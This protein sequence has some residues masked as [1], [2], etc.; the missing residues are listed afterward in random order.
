MKYQK[1]Q[2]NISFAWL[3]AIIVGATILVLAIFGTTRVIQTGT[4]E[5]T[6]VGAR[7]LGILF[8]PLETGFESAVSTPLNVNVETR[9][10]NSCNEF[11]TFGDQEI[12]L[13]EFS[14]NEWSPPSAPASFENKYIFS[15]RRVEGQNFYIF[16]KPF[17]F[18]FKVTDLIYLTSSNEKYCFDKSPEHIGKE[19]SQI[20]QVNLAPNCEDKEGFIKVCFEGG[21]DCDINVN[22]DSKSVEKTEGKVYFEEDAL[23]YAAIFSDNDV[24]ECQVKRLL[25]RT[26]EL[27]LLYQ[28][29]NFLLLER[30]CKRDLGTDLNLFL[31]DLEDIDSSSKLSRIS[32]LVEDLEDKNNN[33]DCELW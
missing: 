2:L 18:P 9:I 7:E 20:G 21:F 6:V 26:K 23:M 14:F 31:N 11:G 33:L 4:Q 3:F 10:H 25:K 29:K 17:E 32:N 8:N 12:R 24:Y 30:G 22:Y 13:S 15:K 19:L 5:Q 1:A 27:G 28:E 16:S